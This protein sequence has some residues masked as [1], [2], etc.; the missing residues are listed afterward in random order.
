MISRL[1]SQPCPCFLV[2]SKQLSDLLP[3]S[4]VRADVYDSM[5]IG[6]R[7]RQDVEHTFPQ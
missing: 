3:L 5:R 6:T 1:S 2:V 7:P 4:R